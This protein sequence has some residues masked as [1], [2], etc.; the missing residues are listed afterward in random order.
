MQQTE[1]NNLRHK[2]FISYSSSNKET[3]DEV[4]S[5]LE[6]AGIRCWIAP[7]NID[8]G[9]A[10]PEAVLEAIKNSSLVVLVFSAAADNSIQIRNEIERAVS[11]GIPILVYR[12]EDVRPT[13]SLE[14]LVSSFHWLNAIVGDPEDH[15]SE[16]VEA[17]TKILRVR[18]NASMDNQPLLMEDIVSQNDDDEIKTIA[19][20]KENPR[21]FGI[22]LSFSLK[23]M[24]TFILIIGSVVVLEILTDVNLGSRVH[25]SRKDHSDT[26]LIPRREMIPITTLDSSR[27]IP[28]MDFIKAIPNYHYT[29][30]GVVFQAKDTVLTRQKHSDTIGLD[31]QTDSKIFKIDIN[32]RTVQIT[33]IDKGDSTKGNPLF[34]HRYASVFRLDTGNT[35]N[36]IQDRLARLIDMTN[37]ILDVQ[38]LDNKEWSLILDTL[39]A[40]R[41]D[42]LMWRLLSDTLLALQKQEGQ[43]NHNYDLG[44]FI[45]NPQGEPFQDSTIL[46]ARNT[47]QD[48]LKSRL[49]YTFSPEME[50]TLG[51][52]VE[53]Y[54]ALIIGIDNYNDP[55]ID[56]LDYAIR[57]AEMF[58]NTITT[59][60]NFDV[61]NVTLIK[62]AT[63]ENIINALDY[64]VKIVRPIDNFLIFYAGHGYWNAESEIGFWLP[65][66]A[67]KNST[68]N[69]F[70]NSALRD[71]LREI[72]SRHTLLITDACF[73]GSIL[74]TCSAFDDAPLAIN[75]LNELP[76][77]KAM[78]SGTLTE[79]HDQ[80]PFLRYLVERLE[81]N[82]EKYL[83]AGQLFKNFRMAVINN[84][85]VLPQFGVIQDVGDE[86]GDFIFILR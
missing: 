31:N 58:Y 57:N 26:S 13:K 50:L 6:T 66:D 18:P 45:F 43:K 37:K 65:N 8:F 83:P 41:R 36:L 11:H 38:K 77:R 79:V 48:S 40:I 69:W 42:S 12:I 54:Y 29:M 60:Y 84:S 74:K 23:I 86:G 17:S 3:A 25:L 32:P 68:R 5:A 51:L 1:L 14:F 22:S 49:E 52:T 33:Q 59:K 10:Y 75:K 16:L 53:V 73:G 44:S 20:K 63:Y 80:S 7:R 78:I 39:M 61:Q 70:R 82:T 21:R 24:F 27:V 9:R 85:K 30:S 62:N 55:M 71:Y 28:K 4:C 15:L 56:S 76:S 35:D 19:K 46:L 64:Y 2:I 34:H 72:Q 47:S 67:Q 81:N